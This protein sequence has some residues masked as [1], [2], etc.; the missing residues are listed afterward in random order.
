MGKIPVEGK[1]IGECEELIKAEAKKYLKEV[2]VK[3]RLLNYKITVI[4]EVKIPGTYYN[5]NEYYT[6]FDAISS[7]QGTTDF[8]KLESVLILRST[9]T[10]TK[11]YDL[12][13]KSKSSLSSD[14]YYLLPNDVVIVQP[15]NN[16]NVA[17]RLPLIAIAIGSLSALL[18][19]LN[20]LK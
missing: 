20:Y 5:Y 8:A 10:G 13:L 7:A 1:T 11:T 19:L 9:K 6:I 15:G 17:Q 16:K 2:T 14:G 12:N 4:G 18:L 3:V